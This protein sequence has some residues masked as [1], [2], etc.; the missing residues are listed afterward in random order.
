M[1]TKL[2][3]WKIDIISSKQN[4]YAAAS[5]GILVK[6]KT[7]PTQGVTVVKIGSLRE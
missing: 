6:G 3:Y 5:F 7:F 1:N 2:K 4:I